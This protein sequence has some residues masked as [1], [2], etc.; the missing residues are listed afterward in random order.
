MFNI[1]DNINED[2]ISYVDKSLRDAKI[3]S[4]I[5]QYENEGILCD[6]KKL[7]NGDIEIYRQEKL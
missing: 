6:A 5:T 4:L 3:F 1:I 2:V 7:D